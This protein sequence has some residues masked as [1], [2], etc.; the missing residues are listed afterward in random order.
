MPDI[1]R[2][3]LLKATGISMLGSLFPPVGYLSSACAQTGLLSSIISPA[4]RWGMAVDIGKCPSG[5]RDCINACHNLH[6]VPTIEKSGDEIR[7]IQKVP[8]PSAFPSQENPYADILRRDREVIVLCNH[9]SNPPCVRVCP[10]QATFKRS[11][12]IVMMD[13]H[14][15]IG[16]RFCI[17]ACPYGARSMNFKDPRPFI[18]SINPEYPTRTRGVVEKCNF[19]EERLAKNLPPACVAACKNKALIFGDLSQTK[20]DICTL[21]KASNAIRRRPELGTDPHVFYTGL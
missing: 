18:K 12:G 6:N 14:R 11:D 1:S 17:A 15:C 19:C 20:S 8:F 4:T 7:W 16:C 21:L 9:C 10:T 13:Y 2:R 5:C 3:L